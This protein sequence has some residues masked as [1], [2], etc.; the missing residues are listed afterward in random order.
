MVPTALLNHDDHAS[1][2]EEEERPRVVAS[3]CR[4]VLALPEPSPSPPRCPE[5]AESIASRAAILRR[6]KA[7][8]AFLILHMW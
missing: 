3:E 1:V 6:R 2:D 4:Q 5:T 8:S 7:L